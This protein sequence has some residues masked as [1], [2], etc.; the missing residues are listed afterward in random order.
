MTSEVEI[1]SREKILKDLE[2]GIRIEKLTLE[3][4]LEL[5]SS[6]VIEY[7]KMNASSSILSGQSN[8]TINLVES[9]LTFK[10]MQSN[11]ELLMSCFQ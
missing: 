9:G 3:S 2:S 6:V 11:S 5:K 10:Q 1:T 7:D 8:S 4:V